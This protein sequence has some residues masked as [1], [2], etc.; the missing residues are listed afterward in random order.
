MSSS[1]SDVTELLL[2]LD[3]SPAE[4]VDL[5]FD[6][7]YGELKR[8]AGSRLRAE[9]PGHTLSATALVN[10]AYLKLADLERLEWKNRAQFFAIAARAMRRILVNHA[11]DRSAGKRG[12]GVA[13]ITLVA[14]MADEPAETSL[15]W[16][17]LLTAEAALDELAELNERQGRVV[18]M[19]IF[20]G[21]THREIAAALE[22]SVPTVERDW[23]L[24]RAFLGRALAG[25]R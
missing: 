13:H 22:V 16:G 15:S 18:E 7:L 2:E 4:A 20:A 17:G 1:S 11:R 23:R 6:R 9:N 3:G 12:G 5:L 25:E 10:E 19:R 8:I 14:G 24:G 21:L